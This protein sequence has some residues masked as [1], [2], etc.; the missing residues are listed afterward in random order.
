MTGAEDAPPDA[1][2]T[3]EGQTP[4]GD[5]EEAGQ[6][7][8]PQFETED[9]TPLNPVDDTPWEERYD[10]I[11]RAWLAGERL[12]DAH[13]GRH[14]LSIAR[15]LRTR[16]SNRSDLHDDG[17]LLAE[18]DRVRQHVGATF[19]YCLL[20]GALREMHHPVLN[21]LLIG[22]RMHR[23]RSRHGRWHL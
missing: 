18:L 23:L 14:F 4:T 7:D 11:E 17:V 22:T 21:P 2:M 19:T 16:L 12:G 10:R 15:I 5:Q 6:G 20:E 1:M 9:E 8:T 13:E 3:A